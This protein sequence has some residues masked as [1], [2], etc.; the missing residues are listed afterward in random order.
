MWDTYQTCVQLSNQE[1]IEEILD[2]Y[3]LLENMKIYP[4]TIEDSI[5]G[6]INLTFYLG[7]PEENK[8]LLDKVAAAG[9]EIDALL[10]MHYNA[11]YGEEMGNKYYEYSNSSY[12]L[13]SDRL[14]YVITFRKKTEDG[15]VSEVGYDSGKIPF[16][17]S[18][19][20]RW[21][22]ESMYEALCESLEK[23]EV[24]E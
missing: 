3:G 16:S 22:A 1:A 8:L 23:V 14:C 18:D 7:T 12:E 6:D 13:S 15:D 10:D 11:N 2:K 4:R 24:A 21:T 17:L 19:A 9:A 5:P 20:D